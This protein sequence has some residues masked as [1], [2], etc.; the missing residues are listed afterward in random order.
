[1]TVVA[2]VIVVKDIVLHDYNDE[3]HLKYD[4]SNSIT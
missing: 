4:T 1:M 3:R 2:K